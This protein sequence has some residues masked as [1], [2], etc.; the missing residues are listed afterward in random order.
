[1][2]RRD[3]GAERWAELVDEADYHVEAMRVIIDGINRKEAEEVV[4]T[5]EYALS[6]MRTHYMNLAE[7]YVIHK[8]IHGE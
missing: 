3:I 6:V 1:M 2:G 7:C 8:R 4:R 5:L